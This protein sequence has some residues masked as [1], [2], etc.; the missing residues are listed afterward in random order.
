MQSRRENA[1]L[2]KVDKDLKNKTP[3][4]LQELVGGFAQKKFAAAYIFSFIHARGISDIN[5]ITPLSKVFRSELVRD[6]YFISH[7]AVEKKLTDPDSTEKYLFK[8]ADGKVIESVLLFDDDRRT[9][10]VST[11]AGCAMGCEFCAT[12]RLGLQ[13]N[14]TAAEIVDQVNS[15]YHNRCRVT[16]VVFMGMGEP[17]A[18][19][20]NTINAVRI[21]NDPAG[22][23]IGIRHL[24]ISTA[25]LV[26]GVEKLADEGVRPRLAVSLNAADDKLRSKLMPINK[27]YPLKPL[28]RAVRRYQLR[29]RQR[30]TFEYVCIKG[31]NDTADD[32]RALARLVRGIRCNVNLI[33]LNPHKGCPFQ[34]SSTAAV[35]RFRQILERTGIKTAVRA[36]LGRNIKA[37][38]GQLGADLNDTGAKKTVEGSTT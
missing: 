36:R 35:E 18:N 23:R 31:V 37:A 9:L 17:L 28:L 30:V 11:Q 15:I 14:L 8:L 19:Y 21:L 25:G 2:T 20:D 29:T 24:T 32:A 16:N 34:P 27:K 3:A 38:C 4:E 22:L 10:C 13:R 33:A 1:G 5:A 26:P 12:A 7:L 6:G